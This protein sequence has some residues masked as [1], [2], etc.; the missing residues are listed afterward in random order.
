MTTTLELARQLLGFNTINPP[1]NETDCMQFFADWL[2][3]SGFEVS[4]SSFGEGR[5]NLIARLPGST[6]GK[7][8]AFTGH[9]DT[10]PLGNAQWQYD[11]FGSQ[12]DAGRLYGRGAS[13]MKAAVAAF[14]VACI[15]Q[16]KDI[17]AGHGAVLLITGGEE[18]GCD[19]ARALIE[20]DKLPEI[21]ALI[22][23]EPTANY[24][25]IGH[26]GALWLRCET[27][28]KTA[29]GA[30]P[31]LGI[32]AIYLAADAL[33]KIRHFSPGAPH[34][35]MKQPTLNVGRI[36]GGLNIN[37]VPD[38]TRFDVDIRSGP[39]LQHATIR[40]QLTTLLGKNVTVST[41]IDL[42]AVLSEEDN[43]WIKQ[44][45]QRCQPLHEKPLEPRV[46][47]YFTDA[48]LLLPALGNPPCIIL[49]PGEPSMAHQTDEYCLL[50]RIDEAE[51]LYGDIIR[52]WMRKC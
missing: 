24:P 8:L 25:I 16:R 1:G 10:V 32:N 19:G 38:H 49:G 37:S 18:T 51:R 11:P 9:L 34:P 41:L 36:E 14:S 45:Y 27:R 30:M 22:V 20:S 29:H 46:V 4:L 7:P 39:N 48:S 13:D 12:M 35:L 33:G 2:R 17:L 28:G 43:A 50:S 21:G 52:D 40:Q 26:K 47:P 6:A 3:D 5:S 15:Q 44:V 31:E 23:G 42:P